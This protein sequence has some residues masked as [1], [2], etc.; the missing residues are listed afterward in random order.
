MGLATGSN[1]TIREIAQSSSGPWWLQLYHV[2]DAVTE[3][4]V[5]RAEAAGYAAVCLT[6]DGVGGRAKDKDVRNQFQVQ[7]G[8]GW[9]EL[10][11]RPDLIA[12]DP[13]LGERPVL[14]W[15]RL[16]WI[17]SLSSMPLVVKGILTVEDAL[18]CVEHGAD[19]IVVSN[20]GGRNMDTAAATIEVL[21]AI[22]QAVG[23]DIEVYMDGGI[24]RGTDVFKALALGARAVLVGRPVMWG[25]AFDGESGVRTMFDILRGE[26]EKAMTFCGV[27]S[28]AEIDSS[29]VT[30]PG[31]P[32]NRRGWPS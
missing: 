10:R 23:G 28:L 4:L 24:R 19:A 21:P 29:M 5:T 18:R 8:T 30:L 13:D 16:A 2:G 11:D 1:N 27:A 32:G 22:A 7:P 12:D 3:L 14:T 20:H 25:L 6:V 31:L 9:A 17:K 26:F 15:S